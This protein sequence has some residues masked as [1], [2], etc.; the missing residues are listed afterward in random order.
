MSIWQ[1]DANIKDLG[2]MHHIQRIRRAAMGCVQQP[3]NFSVFAKGQRL[4]IKNLSSLEGQFREYKS[5]I[6]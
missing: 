6:A 4:V 5:K 1:G 3:F 2:S